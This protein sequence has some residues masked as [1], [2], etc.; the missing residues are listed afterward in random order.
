M[1]L[2]KNREW[3]WH[4]FA[5]LST[6]LFTG[7]LS[8]YL[9]HHLDKYADTYLKGLSVL[10]HFGIH[11]MVGITA[12]MLFLVAYYLWKHK[13]ANE[14]LVLTITTLISHWPDIRFAYR[15]LP[16]EPWEVIF[17]FHTI[18]DESFLVFWFALLVSILLIIYYLRIIKKYER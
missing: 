6:A 12:G 7:Y 1:R 16:H 13:R 15:G 11:Y 14:P 3:W 10:Q 8:S 5:L 17:L 9:S 2:L 4:V 18:A